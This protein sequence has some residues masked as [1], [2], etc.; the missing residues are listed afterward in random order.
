MSVSPFH[1]PRHPWRFIRQIISP[2]ELTFQESVIQEREDEI[3]EIEAGIHELN[4]IFRDLGTLVT[5]QGEMLGSVTSL[6]MILR[7][8]IFSLQITSRVMLRLSHATLMLPTKSSAS[9]QSISEKP[10]DVLLV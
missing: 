8:P 9:P 4:E 6:H 1:C 2:A 10:G 7:R 5:E 3:R